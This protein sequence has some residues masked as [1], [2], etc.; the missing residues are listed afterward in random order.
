MNA[1]SWAAPPVQYGMNFLILMSLPGATSAV[2]ITSLFWGPWRTSAH[3]TQ[4]IQLGSTIWKSSPRVNGNS[5][6]LLSLSSQGSWPSSA[7]THFRLQR[8]WQG[9]MLNSGLW[10]FTSS[11]LGIGYWLASAR[12]LGK[13]AWYQASPESSVCLVNERHIKENTVPF[14]TI[15]PSKRV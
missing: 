5:L 6:Q 15:W 14:Q 9:L 1:E 10:T 4:Y 13:Q 7:L 2:G 3:W 12:I 8:S 11:F